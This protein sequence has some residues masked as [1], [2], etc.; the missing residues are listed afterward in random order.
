VTV[1]LDGILYNGAALFK[2]YI[3]P[4]FSVVESGMLSF[5]IMYTIASVIAVVLEPP[6]KT[7]KAISNNIIFLIHNKLFLRSNDLISESDS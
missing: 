7:V 6:T 3:K 1:F 5:A 4:G 2:K